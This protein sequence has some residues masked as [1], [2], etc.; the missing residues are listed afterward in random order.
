[1][2][3]TNGEIVRRMDAEGYKVAKTTVAKWR[4]GSRS[5]SKENMLGLAKAFG[6]TLDEVMEAHHGANL[7]KLMEVEELT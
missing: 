3:L 4:S 5:P 7:A 2:R 1:M 6:H